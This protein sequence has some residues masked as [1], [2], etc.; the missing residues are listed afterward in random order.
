MDL[1]YVKYEKRGHIAWVTINRPE[2]RN[3]L[4]V[5]AHHE[6][7]KVWED[8]DSDP[9][10]RV[11]IITGAGE[12]AFSAGNDLKF[13][14]ELA[15]S[16]ERP[17]LPPLGGFGG[18]TNP[19]FKLWK[20]VIAAVNGFALGGGFE[21]ALACDIII[22]A[23]HAEF[24]LPEPRVGLTAGAGGMHRLPRQVPMKV[25]MG[26]MLTGKRL[27]AQDAYRLGL[28]NEVV[29]LAD[30]LATA[31]RWANEVMEC[32]PMSVR[33]SKQAATTGLDLPLE[34]AMNNSY[35]WVDRQVNS[36]DRLEGMRAFVEKRS[37]QWMGEEGLN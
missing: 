18:F 16:G 31:E 12:K 26:M 13:S 6:M 22:A 20:P 9:N 4:H 7:F 34:A 15:L 27:S 33:G 35:F 11:A 3:A 32:A 23:D 5:L 10:L 14:T 21:L 2:V 29:P 8:F 37:P 19:R 28:A 30:L 25:A 24:G 1:K 36:P 17:P